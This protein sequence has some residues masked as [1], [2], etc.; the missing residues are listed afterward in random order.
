MRP[1]TMGI[2]KVSIIVTTYN[3]P[4]SDVYECLKSIQNLRYKNYEVIL[5]DNSSKSP[6]T[7]LALE[8]NGVHVV[9]KT[10]MENLGVPGGRNVGANKATGDY[11]FFVD[12]DAVLDADCLGTLVST[13]EADSSIGVLGPLT[14]RYDKPAQAWFY[15]HQRSNQRLFDVKMVVGAAFMVR[16]KMFEQVGLFDSNY[17]LYHEEW[18]LCRRVQQAGYRTVCVYGASCWHK[19]S[20]NDDSKLLSPNRAY[21][22]HRNLFLFAKRNEGSLDKVFSFLFKYLLYFG[23]GSTPTYFVVLSLKEKKFGALKAYLHGIVDGVALFAKL[24][25]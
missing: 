24:T 25:S 14:Y 4:S 20:D 12:D 2:P 13:A 23:P 8:G 11:I 7:Y 6:S 9:D 15:P 21:Y 1:V 19:V 10:G 22:Y 17:F 5:V 3:R 18:D 16:R